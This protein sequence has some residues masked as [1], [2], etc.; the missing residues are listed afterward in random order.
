MKK[1]HSNINDFMNAVSSAKNDDTIE[2]KPGIYDGNVDV[3][4]RGNG[5]IK[6]IMHGITIHGDPENKQ[7]KYALDLCGN[8][9]TVLADEIKLIG[10]NHGA[11]GVRGHNL[12][13]ISDLKGYVTGHDRG[14]LEM[15]TNHHI[16]GLNFDGLGNIGISGQGYPIESNINRTYGRSFGW[17]PSNNWRITQCI[18]QNIQPMESGDAGG[19]FRII[20][21]AK[22]VMVDNCIF[23]N[24]KGSGLWGDHNQ[25]GFEWYYNLF[26]DIDTEEAFGKAAFLEIM[27]PDP[28]DKSGFVAKIAGNIFRRCDT[29]TILIAAS[30]GQNP[31]GIDVFGN[32]IEDGWGI[33]AGAMQRTFKRKWD[34]KDRSKDES[35]IARL[36]NIRIRKNVIRPTTGRTHISIFQGKNSGLIE[37]AGNYYVIGHEYN[38]K[39]PNGLIETKKVTEAMIHASA[40]DSNGLFIHGEN[41][42]AHLDKNA[43]IGE[44]PEKFPFPEVWAEIP[45]EKVDISGGTTHVP[46][47]VIDDPIIDDLPTYDGLPRFVITTDLHKGPDW[48]DWEAL[49]I[50]LMYQ[51]FAN[52]EKIIIASSKIKTTGALE[53]FNRVFKPAYEEA[54]NALNDEYFKP[55][56]DVMEASSNGE[57]FLGKTIDLD[58][59]PSTKAIIDLIRP[60]DVLNVLW[61]GTGGECANV[62]KWIEDNDPSLMENIRFI[63]HAASLPTHNNYKKD[64]AAALYMQHIGETYNNYCSAGF[65]GK[66]IDGRHSYPLVKIDD[67]GTALG[68]LTHYKHDMIGGGSPETDA[69]DALIF[70]IF[71]DWFGGGLSYVNSLDWSGASNENE[72]KEDFAPLRP[73]LFLD[74]SGRFKIIKEYYDTNR[75][76]EN[77]NGGNTGSEVIDLQNLLLKAMTAVEESRVKLNS[78]IDILKNIGE[79][80]KKI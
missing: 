4:F 55:S 3:D 36:E 30:S 53:E 46:D 14:C 20:P 11:L 15:G 51:D 35:V 67:H 1:I 60:D 33:T 6:V 9:T 32:I 8:N 2:L 54:A 13:I 39:K 17:F 12:E 10:G 5:K 57:G 16:Q 48:D 34:A 65:S 29:Q 71:L 61:W 40:S 31:A 38:F 41:N 80:L 74:I 19:G 27:D 50:T 58:K 42:A 21:H 52:I 77:N 56:L 22:N 45:V 49:A 68:R 75:T 70:L 44:M 18:F 72:I 76:G 63:S 26:E 66:V 43:I 25:K 23:R 64:S 59:Y 79:E 62:A 78:A 37:I 73:E 28:S 24:I 69:S 47:P 7:E